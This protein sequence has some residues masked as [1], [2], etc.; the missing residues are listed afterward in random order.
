MDWNNLIGQAEYARRKTHSY[1]NDTTS[2]YVMGGYRIG[3]FLPYYT[4]GK[5]SIDHAPTYAGA[6]SCP[7]GYPAACTPTLRALTA[8]A[9]TVR[10]SGVSQGEQSTDSVGLRWDLY[11]AAALKVQVDRIKPKNGKGLLLNATPGFN[12]AITVGTVAVDF[13]F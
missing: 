7:A 8:G 13:V 10:S 3:K 11:S 12:H 5:L 1:I 4:H 6:T 2:W 9:A